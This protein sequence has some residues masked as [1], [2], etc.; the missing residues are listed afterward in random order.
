VIIN[1]HEMKLIDEAVAGININ[2]CFHPCSVQPPVCLHGGQCR[3]DMDRYECR[4]TPD[5]DGSHC[6]QSM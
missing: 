4:C 2:N 6:E 5:F 3:P 1:G